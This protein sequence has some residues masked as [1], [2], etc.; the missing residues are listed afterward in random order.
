MLEWPL[1][2]HIRAADHFQKAHAL[3]PSHVPSVRG[4]RRT[5]VAL[6]RYPQALPF[7]D[8]EI[9]LTSDPQQKAVVY[10]EKGLVLEDS[11]GS[12]PE[13]RA[14][15]EAGLDLDPTNTSLLKA[16]ERSEIAAK[17]WDG[18]DRTYERAANAVV[19]DTRLKAAVIA[20]R[21]RIVEARRGDV[22]GA[23]EL[24][25][26]A[27]ETDPRTTTAIHALK[28][29]CF[30][31]E[32]FADLVTVLSREADLVADPAARAFAFYRAGRVQSDRL[33]ALQQAAQSFEKAA[34]EAPDDRVVLEELARAY[35]LGKQW[36]ELSTVLERLARLSQRPFE[37]VGYYHRMGQIAEERLGSDESATVWYEKARA[38]DPVYLPALQALVKL[39]TKREA[40]AELLTV[41]NGE[42]EGALDNGRRAAAHARMAEIYERR[43]GNL[44]Q[45]AEHHQK[46]LGLVPGFA[47]AFKAL[48]RLLTQRGQFTELAELYERAVDLAADVE[49]KT[50]WLF[51]IG[52]LYEDALGEY[53]QALAAYGRIVSGDPKHLGAIHAMQ[54]AAERGG[55]WKELISALEL[56]VPLA[57]DK[58][59][60]VEILLR[61]GEVAEVEI[62]DEKLSLAYFR[63]AVEI[64]PTHAAALSSLGRLHYKAG[65]WEDLLET[66]RSE[67]A[68]ASKGPAAAA[69]LFKMGE[70]FEER[71]GKDEDALTSYRR[72]V[73]ADATHRPA[74]HA[75]ERKL[76]EKGKWDELVRLLEVELAG[77]KNADERSRAS[78][79]IGEVYENRL[80][81]PDKALLSYEQSLSADSEFRP[82]RDG[83]VRLLTQAKDWKRLVEELD[84]EAKGARDPSLAVAA[85][86]RAGELFRDELADPARA[87]ASFEAVLERDPAHVEALLALEPLYAEKGSWEA[88]AKVYATEARVL[89]DPG[90][91]IAV[92]RELARLE[93]RR[94]GDDLKPVREAQIMVLQLAPSDPAALAALE[95]LALR[96]GDAAEVGQVD[97]Q[98]A[99]S[100]DPAVAAEHTTRLAELLEASGDT[101]ALGL[102]RNALAR[103]PDNVAA[104]CGFARMAERLRDPKLLEEAASRLVEVALDRPGAARLYVRAGEVQSQGGDREG[105]ASMFECAL[106]VSPEHEPAATRLVELLG[107]SHDPARLIRALSQAAAAATDRDRV[108]ALWIQVADLQAEKKRDLAAAL[109]ALHRALGI[110]PGHVAILTRLSELYVRDG[111]WAQAVDRLNQIVGQAGAPEAARLDAHARLAAILDE[112]LGEPDRAR[113]SVEA[114]LAVDPRHAAA[115]A[116]LVKLEIRRGRL[117]AAGDAAGRLVSVSGSPE[118]RV[119]AL[120]AQGRVEKA[121][122]RRG[123]AGKAFAEAI[124]L[125]GLGSDAAE[126]LLELVTEI[127][128]KS[129]AP[130]WD[131]YL[132]AL[133][134][135]AEKPSATSEERA[136]VYVEIA[137]VLGGPLGQPDQAIQALE[138][139]LALGADPALHAELA[140]R[141]LE[142]G[143]PGKAMQSLRRVLET[144]PRNGEAWRKLA[145]CFK[146]LGKRAEATL[147]LS[148]LAALGQANDLE[149]ATLAQTPSRPASAPP[150]SFD[151]AELEAMG[152]L[153]A[154]DPAA[155]LLSELSDLLEKIYE[156]EL[157]RYGLGSRD[158]LGARSGHPLRQLAD[159]VGA[160]FGVNDFDLYVHGTPAAGLEVEFTD[161]VS[162]L[163]PATVTKLPESAQVFMLAR[164]HAN[165]ARKLHAVDRLSAEQLELLLG[166]AARMVDGSFPATSSG[167]DAIASLS[168][169]VSRAL[170]WIGRGGIEDAARD[171]SA[172]RRIDSAEWVRRV[173]TSAARAALLVSDDLSQAV[174]AIRRSEGDLSGAQ[175]RSLAEATRLAEDLLGFW[176][177]EGAIATR[178]RL[179][180]L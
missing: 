162:I 42:A 170:P 46:A 132:G 59:R 122:G 110:L 163:V 171:Y 160:I 62:A 109:A 43:L 34:A 102:F 53:A 67:L 21:A 129:D 73:D 3:L 51:K 142:A 145:D 111:Q 24:Y 106:E 100:N 175:G 127:P 20:E 54:R 135:F 157:Q 179:G 88:L 15:F 166:A 101:S 45:A 4:A 19:K 22:K 29:L 47:P 125:A 48:E 58:K 38:L 156:P 148:V 97:A 150:R 77:T 178:K 49:N 14:A 168:R 86:L 56:E 32:R 12:R 65:R 174:A 103:E 60:R 92:L 68:I 151:R 104:A 173:R 72:A 2:E 134:R 164:I 81:Q 141:L 80:R 9:R 91:R 85:L 146:G 177:S 33:G 176:V 143:N 27:L 30:A 89:S 126:A 63:K 167:E 123:T 136:P 28:R 107:S 169:R 99:S 36:G 55:R 39:Y 152:L 16:V 41:H 147:T 13:A 78:F 154:S 23:T 37:Q 149:L 25:R 114:V 133:G 75:L 10:Y 44:E 105:A 11:M 172:A 98:L 120:T 130:G 115:L 5:L 1:A 17:A 52:R 158:R 74:L 116:R 57:N 124:E 112:R 82:A 128:R 155:R 140:T 139:G 6:K 180:L 64:D 7:F 153:P 144:D 18:L 61:A 40:F 95:R 161:P 70:I 50:T 8:A 79:R 113:A 117:D 84:K 119:E 96:A 87:V 131:V 93:E 35:E 90:A 83:R 66:Y 26:L 108:A 31:E 159:R 165:L 94:A 76:R 71:V 69:L 137:R 138:R 118:D 121:R